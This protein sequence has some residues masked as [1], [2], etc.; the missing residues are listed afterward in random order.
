MWGVGFSPGEMGSVSPVKE[1]LGA[2]MD[3]SFM[4]GLI[5]GGFTLSGMWMGPS[6]GPS[7]IKFWLKVTVC[8]VLVSK[9][10]SLVS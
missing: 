7:W 6:V 8:G 9:F 1:R 10:L 3:V 2:K 5:G 4:I